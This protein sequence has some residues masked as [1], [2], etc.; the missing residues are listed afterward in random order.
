MCSNRSMWVWVG[1]LVVGVGLPYAIQAGSHSAESNVTTVDTRSELRSV[2]GRAVAAKT[3]A[4]L[5]GVTV[6]YAGSTRTTDSGGRFA[7]EGGTWPNGQDLTA[8]K[9]GYAT[10][11]KRVEAPSG[12]AAYIVPDVPLATGYP[13]VVGVEGEYE[14]LFLAGVAVDNEYTATVEWGAGHSPG[15]VEFS[16]KARPWR[17]TV[18]TTGTEA[19]ITEDVNALFVPSFVPGANAMVVVAIDSNGNRSDPCFKEVGLL[20]MPGPLGWVASQWP[21]T[22][23]G[24]GRWAWT[25]TS[26]T[27]R[28]GVL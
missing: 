20:P 24:T 14:G 16:S 6:A 22:A 28:F 9:E 15:S 3:L 19:S 27:R 10:A 11:R 5:P 18:T 23:Y 25:G 2:S 12:A 7:F 17:S 8:T 21:F 1:A 26:P 4:G 13:M